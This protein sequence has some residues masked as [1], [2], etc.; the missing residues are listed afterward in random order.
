MNREQETSLRRLEARVSVGPASPPALPIRGETSDGLVFT[1]VDGVTVIISVKGAYK[2]PAVRSYPTGLD[3]AANAPSLWKDQ[4]RWDLDNRDEARKR[5]TGHLRPIVGLDLR[6][7]HPDC[8]C[9]G[10]NTARLRGRS[11]G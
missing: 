3:S 10:E 8:L 6:C 4:E 1:E 5:R 11:L 2:I 7:G 9:C